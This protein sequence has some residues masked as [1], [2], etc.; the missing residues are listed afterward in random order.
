[1]KKDGFL[2]NLLLIFCG[3][4]FDG[5][6]FL[7][8]D[9][10]FANTQTGN[11]VKLVIYLVEG[12]D[13]LPVL[14]PII[15]FVVGVAVARIL[16]RKSTKKDVI[17][18][19]V[20]LALVIG[21]AFVPRS[22]QT[23]MIANCMLSIVCAFQFQVF[24]T[25]KGRFFATIM[26]SNNLRK[27]VENTVDGVIDKSKENVR[28]AGEVSLLV[29]AFAFGVGVSAFT[30]KPL[31]TYSALITTAPLLACLIGIIVAESKNKSGE[32][33]LN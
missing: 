20:E 6:S 33:L 12:V 24:H 3:G 1:M 7:L 8:R 18:M 19:S 23:N 4:F 30:Y 25:L 22:Y 11:V 15:A 10:V 2:F 29:L 16:E 28:F 14:F 31:G 17:A 21:V 26:C 27:V 32:R 9:K 5:Y 13:P